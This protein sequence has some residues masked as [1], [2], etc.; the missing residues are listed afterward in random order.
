MAA[1]LLPS[2]HWP[3][4]NSQAC[5]RHLIVLPLLFCRAAV[6]PQ[7]TGAPRATPRLQAATATAAGTPPQQP[8][9]AVPVTAAVSAPA[10]ASA[11]AAAVMAGALAEAEMVVAAVA[12]SH[13]GD[14]Q[15]RPGASLC[16]GSSRRN[17][18][19]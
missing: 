18:A 13:A 16:G 19:C 17:Q 11:A 15:I 4:E 7:L 2:L 1:V 14:V 3:F 5:L 8:M 10:A 9:A 12:T 6:L